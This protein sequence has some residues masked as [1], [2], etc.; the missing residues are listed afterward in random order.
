MKLFVSL[1]VDQV[2]E[3]FHWRYIMFP[4]IDLRE[5][6]WSGLLQNFTWLVLTIAFTSGIWRLYLK[7]RY[8]G[9]NV[10]LMK[11]KDPILT[12]KVSINKAR[13]CLE[14]ESEKAVFLKGIVSPYG[15]L[16]CDIIEEGLEKDGPN[17]GLLE[18]DKRSR[19]WII[20]LDH[21]GFE[22]ESRYNTK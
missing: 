17:R 20:H 16:T 6:F 22:L 15:R 1:I 21:P 18:E 2:M 11:G 5:W 3:N 8:G 13:E 4:W 10:T 7:W 14:D 12:R 9:W 19:K